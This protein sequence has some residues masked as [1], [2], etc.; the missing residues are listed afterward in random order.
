MTRR[1][2]LQTAVIVTAAAASALALAAYRAVGTFP[3]ALPISVLDKGPGGLVTAERIGAYPRL[4]LQ[5]LLD[6]A[7]LPDP[8][9][10][11]NGATLYRIRYRT[12]NQNGATVVA[13]GLVALPSTRSP[14]SAIT[15]FHGTNAQRN[16]APSQKTSQEGL[17]AAGL[18]SGAGHLLLAPDYI[19][20][21]ESRAAHPYLHTKT[22]VETCID[23]LKA[24]HGL[25][26]VLSIPWPKSLYLMGFSQGG[27]ATLAVQRA[28]EKLEDPR[29]RVA[30]AAP[31]AGPFNLRDISFPQALTGQTDS[32]VYYLAY[33]ASAYAA[34]YKQPIDSLLAKPYGETVPVLFDGDH[35]SDIISA[36][37]PH[38]PRD[39]FV[40]EFLAAYDNGS[41]HW[42]LD[43]LAEN[44]VRDWTPQAPVK[45][46]FGENDVDVSPEEARSAEREMK[47]RGAD[48]TAVSVGPWEHNASV[49]RAVPL[50][51][52]WFAT[53][54]ANETQADGN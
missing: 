7:E 27:H 50:A 54:E 53:L 16:S 51:L 24:S 28:L 36:A 15:Y 49:L 21:G 25:L 22:T 14:G 18:V 31:I 32:H 17:L 48:V 44:S 52:K 39:L 4:I 42:F 10:V 8:V 46:Y 13:S 37:L 30:A 23:F 6:R 45:I 3:V 11:A 43:A 35:E 5:T 29:F 12:T 38:N 40:P 33:L 47:A 41:A 19:G 2:V 9:T 34:V 20:L 26:G 1:R